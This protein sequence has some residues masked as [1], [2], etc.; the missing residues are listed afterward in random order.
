[1]E[2]IMNWQ[3]IISFLGGA[4]IFATLIGFIGKTAI[5]AYVAGRVESY[6]SDLEKITVEHTIRFQRLHG[7]RADVIKSVYTHISNLD[8]SLSSALGFFQSV[9]EPRA[10]LPV[11]R[12]VPA[13]R[14]IW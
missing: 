9:N 7:E 5:D 2:N 12:H 6:K 14:W 8:E 4:S 1:M 10:R 13:P 3:E 11:C